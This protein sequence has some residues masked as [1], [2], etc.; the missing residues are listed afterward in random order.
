MS[1]LNQA[2]PN[3]K[4]LREAKGFCKVIFC[5]TINLKTNSDE[6]NKKKEVT[7]EANYLI[8]ILTFLVALL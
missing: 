1:L 8:V 5:L 7:A 4:Q 3:A 2:L 6:K